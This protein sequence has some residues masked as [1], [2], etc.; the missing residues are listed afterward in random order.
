MNIHTGYLYTVQPHNH[1]PNLNPTLHRGV[2]SKWNST[3]WKCNISTFVCSIWKIRSAQCNRSKQTRF[4]N[5]H[6]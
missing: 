6:L 5:R 2:N 3:Q 4:T 1:D